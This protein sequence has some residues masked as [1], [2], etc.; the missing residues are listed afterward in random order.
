MLYYA[1][2]TNITD[3]EDEIFARTGRNI[4]IKELFWPDSYDMECFRP[5]NIPDS[6]DYDEYSE[7]EI[8][9]FKYLRTIYPRDAFVLIDMT[10]K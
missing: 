3:V 1:A 5:I 2:V 4:D 8:A 10:R 9:V 7:D 6:K